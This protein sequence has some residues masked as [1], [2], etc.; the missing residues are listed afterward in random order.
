MRIE[1]KIHPGKDLT[2]TLLAKNF[3]ITLLL[4]GLINLNYITT[5]LNADATLNL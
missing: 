5:I 4:T 3:F 1:T 2:A